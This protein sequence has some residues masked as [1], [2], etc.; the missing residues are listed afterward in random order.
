MGDSI[1]PEWSRSDHTRVTEPNAATAATKATITPTSRKSRRA[2]VAK[3]IAAT[4]AAASETSNATAA[5]EVSGG[6]AT[7]AASTDAT[8]TAHWSAF[9][10]VPRALS[11]APPDRCFGTRHTS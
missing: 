5:A 4:A 10:Y 8:I 3:T 1:R 11:H 7:A 9:W 2:V 6:C